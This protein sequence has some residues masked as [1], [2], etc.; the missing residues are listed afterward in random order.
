MSGAESWV[1]RPQKLLAGSAVHP[2][3]R[4]REI[5]KA[6]LA[7]RER[8]GPHYAMS[9]ETASLCSPPGRA[10]AGREEMEGEEGVGRGQERS[11]QPWL[12]GAGGSLGSCPR[13]TVPFTLSC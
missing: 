11:P 6:V 8:K 2:L 5:E 7:P 10:G 1:S 12:G 9:V 4:F 13:A 3:P